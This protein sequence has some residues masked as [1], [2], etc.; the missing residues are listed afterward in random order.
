MIYLTIHGLVAPVGC[1]TSRCIPTRDDEAAAGQATSL[2]HIV[3]NG[4]A[5]QRH[6][7]TPWHRIQLDRSRLSKVWHRSEVITHVVLLHLRFLLMWYVASL[8]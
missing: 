1:A 5:R 4:T 8:Q 2:E 7:R 6:L 3:C